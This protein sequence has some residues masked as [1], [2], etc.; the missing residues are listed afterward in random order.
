MSSLLLSLFLLW[1]SLKKK[2]FIIFD[3]YADLRFPMSKSQE[4]TTFRSDDNLDAH[5]VK[6]PGLIDWHQ[7]GP[8]M[9]IKWWALIWSNQLISPAI[10]QHWLAWTWMCSSRTAH[11][12]SGK[13][14][15]TPPIGIHPHRIATMSFS[16]T[17]HWYVVKA[18]SWRCISGAR[19]TE[20]RKDILTPW[21]FILR[22]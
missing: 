1:L 15:F 21:H 8:V 4:T 13:S 5:F 16:L 2:C 6:Q 19:L 12:T 18:T 11:A 20:L 3:S 9:S 17:R 10:W 22:Q 14:P 7:A